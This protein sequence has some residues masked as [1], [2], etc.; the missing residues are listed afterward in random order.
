MKAVGIDLGTTNSAVAT[1]V[2]PD[3][4]AA[5]VPN[6]EGDA[7]TPS[8]VAIR[9]RNGKELRYVGKTAANYAGSDPRNTVTSV[10]RLMG[11]DF[12]DPVV[13]KARKRLTYEVTETSDTDPQA[14]VVIGGRQFSPVEISS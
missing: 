9:S 1:Y 10:K 2:Q 4:R 13:V 14:S 3:K 5:I 8:A 6:G 12:A 7:L 11:R